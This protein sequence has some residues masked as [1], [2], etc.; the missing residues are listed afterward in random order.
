MVAAE[1]SPEIDE[2]EENEEEGEEDDDDDDDELDDKRAGSLPHML[3]ESVF[4]ETNRN[5]DT[6]STASRTITVHTAN[7]GGQGQ[8]SSTANAALGVED[9]ASPAK[10]E[11]ASRKRKRSADEDDADPVSR[12]CSRRSIMPA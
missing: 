6:N 5:P 8:E 2:D 12:P 7:E 3:K 11:V 10:H 4:D 9:S 1:K